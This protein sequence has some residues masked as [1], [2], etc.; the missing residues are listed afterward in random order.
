MEDLYDKKKLI[1]AVMDMLWEDMI[2]LPETRKE[3][4]PLAKE[5][6]KRYEKLLDE[7]AC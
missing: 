3:G 7:E 4:R 6:C 1:K 5:V 2:W